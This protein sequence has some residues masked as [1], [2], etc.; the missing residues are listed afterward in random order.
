MGIPHKKQCNRSLFGYFCSQSALFMRIWLLF[1]LLFL[2]SPAFS[3]TREV[4]YSMPKDTLIERRK[5]IMEAIKETE[6]QLE[7]I[8]NDKKATMGQLRALQNKLADRQRLIGN[9]N[10]ELNGIDQDIRK[11]NNEVLT[12]KQKLE[13]LQT[14]YAQTIRYSYSSRSSYNMLA[15]LFSSRDFND[16]MRRMKFLKKFRDYRKQQSEEITSTQTH[17]KKKISELNSEKQQKDILLNVQVQQKHVLQQETEQTNMVVQDLK[18]KESKLIADIEK[19]KKTTTRINKAIND[20]IEREMAKAAEAAKKAAGTTAAT[21]PSK[22]SAPKAGAKTGTTEP[23][24]AVNDIPRTGS[25]P[26]AEVSLMLTPEDVELA[27]NFEGNKGR[28]LWP[29]EKGYIIEH[30]GTHPHPLAPQVM[31]DCPGVGIQTDERANVR[32][33]FDGTVSKVF[34]VAGSDWVVMVMHGNYFTVYSGL[35]SVSVKVNDHVSAKQV[36]GKVATNEEGIPVINFQIWKS[37]GKA[38]NAKLNPE[39]W[40][41]RPR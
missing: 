37:S 3:Q 1:F 7:A 28:M 11:S 26:K 19:N 41:G 9:I 34:T 30:F 33:V 13:N 29:V 17:L 15:Y 12:L 24:V 40:I 4:Q 25:K 39:Q 21:E 35:E 5:A 8:K 6:R 31:V 2:A 27:G 18:S 14:R 32:A 20:L 36:I 10:D 38:G 23:G 16:A 22:T